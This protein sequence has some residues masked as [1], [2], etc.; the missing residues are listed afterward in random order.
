[1]SIIALAFRLFGRV[2][3]YSDRARRFF[4]EVVLAEHRCPKCGGCLVMVRD[5]QCRCRCCQHRFDP[6]VVFQ[7]CPACGSP[8][9][10]MIR[11]YRCTHCLSDVAS[12]FCFEAVPLDAAY[13]RKKMA[14]HRQRKAQQRQRIRQMLAESRSAALGSPPIDLDAVPGLVDALNGLAAGLDVSAVPDS[15]N[16]FDLAEYRAHILA[17][18]DDPPIAFQHIEPLDPTDR[19]DRVWRFVTL[20]FMAH[21]GEIVLEQ[22]GPIIWIDHATD[23]EGQG[24]LGEAEAVDGLET[25]VG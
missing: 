9:K 16:R 3:R 5:G 17:Q 12:R 22:R 24:V 18:L 1:M 6:T 15:R 20:I 14:E 25:P 8:V 4:Y 2:M 13:F 10:L 19:L 7:R 23:N 11:R 21:E